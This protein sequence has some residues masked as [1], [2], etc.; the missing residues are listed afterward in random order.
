[1]GGLFYPSLRLPRAA[2]GTGLGLWF[3]R[4]NARRAIFGRQ[5]CATDPP[6]VRH[7]AVPRPRSR[8]DAAAGRPPAGAA[9]NRIARPGL[10]RNLCADRGYRR[11]PVDTA[12]SPAV[13]DH[14]A[15]S[16]PGLCHPRHAAAGARDMVVI[17]DIIVQGVQ[18]LLVLML[19]PLL[20]G[21]VRKITDRLVSRPGPT[22]FLH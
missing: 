15:I 10:E 2:A 22:F 4:R 18:M 12:Q 3:L 7:A 8:H 14:P 17:S 21:L 5:L 20:T 13:P 16:Q 9:Q 19:A 1:V 11:L 6:R